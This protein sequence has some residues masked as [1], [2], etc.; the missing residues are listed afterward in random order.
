MAEVNVLAGKRSLPFELVDD[1]GL[2][3][4]VVELKAEVPSEFADSG[5]SLLS[6]L[7]KGELG[8]SMC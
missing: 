7:D 3:N 4:W 8:W 1:R 2:T 5:E 6:G